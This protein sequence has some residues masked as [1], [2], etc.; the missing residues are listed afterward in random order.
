MPKV[1]VAGAILACSHGGQAKLSGGDSR[2]TVSG[3]P[4]ITAG[5]E[6]GVSFATGSPGLVTPCP[7][8]NKTPPPPTIPC[9]ATVAA[10]AGVST[11]WTVGGQ[12]VLLANATGL[13][14][15]AN[16]PAAKWSVS[17]PGQSLLDV[18]H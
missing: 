3:R 5:Q 15:N 7:N 11:L 16:D 12:G 2:L 4:A 18:D 1:V 6:A 9:T 17:D 13:A 14:T 10:T 8:P